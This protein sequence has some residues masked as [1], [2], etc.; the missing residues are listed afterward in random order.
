VSVQDA[1]PHPILDGFRLSPAQA[2]AVLARGRAVVVTAGAGSGK[3]STLAARYLSL[4]AEG[5]PLRKIIAVTFT[6]KAAREMRSRVRRAVAAYLERPGLAPD[7]RRRWQDAVAGLDAARISTIHGLCLEILRSQPAEAEADPGFAVLNEAQSGL[8]RAQAVDAA[9]RIAAGDSGAGRLF[10]LLGEC[11][12]RDALARL[13]DR[14]PEA[15]TAFSALTDPVWPAWEPR[16]LAPIQG[17]VDDSEVC[18]RFAE[19]AAL[20]DA[21][22]I[23]RAA[24]RGDPQAP[25]LR[26]ALEQW[27]AIVAARKRDDWDALSLRLA[28]LRAALKQV[29]RKENWPGA[30]PKGAVKVLQQRY[31][32]TLKELVGDSGIDLGLDRALAAALP[33]V[34]TLFEAAGEAY[35]AAKAAVPA[36]DFDDLELMALAVLERAPAALERWRGE[37]AALLVDECQDTNAR[38][39]ALVR[40][41]AGET[42]ERLFIVGDAKQSIYGFRGADVAVFRRER[43]RIAASGGLAIPMDETY[44]AHGP[45]VATLNALLQPVLGAAEPGLPDYVQ[46][47]EPLVAVRPAPA[48]GFAGPAVEFHVAAGGRAGAARALAARISHLVELGGCRLAGRD[49]LRPLGYGDIVILC[50]SGGSFAAIEDALDAA[51]IPYLTV[52]GRGFYN[53]P[54]IRD[55]LNTL[56][57]LADPHDDLALAGLLRSPAFALSDAALLALAR[58]RQDSREPTGGSRAGKPLRA[59]PSRSLWEALREHGALLQGKDGPRAARA[60]T[61][62][63]ELHE[64]AGRT[65]VSALLAALL[66]RTA[67]RAVLAAGGDRRAGRNV[68]KLLDDAAASHVVGVRPFL[69]YVA[70]LRGLGSREGEARSPEEGV[71]Q[72]MS[73][74]AAKGMEFPVVVLGDANFGRTPPDGLLLDSGLG[75]VLPVARDGRN[76]FLHRLVQQERA[77]QGAAEEARLLY[78]AATRASER[79]I[80]AAGASLTATGKLRKFDGWLAR[81]AQDGA[82][83][84]LA[85]AGEAAAG[86]AGE[87]VLAAGGQDVAVSWYGPDWAPAPRAA[88]APPAGAQGQISVPLL[89][90]VVGAGEADDG[91]VAPADRD[92]PRRV[93]RVAPPAGRDVPAWTVG[94]LVHR[95][96]AA[97]RFPGAEGFEQ[98]ALATARDLGITGSAD[99]TAA[100]RRAAQLLTRFCGDPLYATMAGA[101]RRLHEV[102]Y[103]RLLP[104]G[105]L[106]NGI[107]DALFLADGAWT[108]VEFKTDRLRDRAALQAL[109][110]GSDYLAQARRY[111]GALAEVTGSRPRMLLV[112]LDCAGEVIALDAEEAGASL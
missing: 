20:E 27:Q 110:D 28:P 5:L 104:D 80:V 29:G 30:D 92:P 32:E 59:P 43:E 60:T 14:A 49:G 33:G 74:H 50:R 26:E 66:D 47:F 100:A 111:A 38:Q 51:G 12:L 108:A 81:F 109:L 97:W 65:Q 42:G 1:A 19:L 17:F 54:E 64:M 46:P 40:L 103:S 21:G 71:V 39:Y 102:P 18:A 22:L 85:D 68:A 77:R 3:T 8:L 52:A 79:L 24:E 86:Q 90:P 84:E 53:R 101:V 56:R 9:M 69:D 63:A 55:L 16:L 112:F 45:L 75:P 73:A 67:Y 34:K 82:L 72:I 76:S 107:V 95:A 93:W 62:V 89:A 6:D 91:R 88:A 10:A 37:A 23:D 2:P 31:D 15:E 48:P 57:A 87:T 35:F 106:E 13:L 41:L 78:V 4:L 94:A 105:T 44:R 7:E 83:P 61:I 96:L 99:A 11:G 58:S 70:Q 98:W 36:L 25:A